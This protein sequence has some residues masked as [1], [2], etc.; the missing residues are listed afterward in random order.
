VGVAPLAFTGIFALYRTDIWVP[1]RTRP[2]L[3]A[4]RD[5]RS[6]RLVMVFGRLRSDATPGQTSADLTSSKHNSSYDE[7]DLVHD[8]RDLNRLGSR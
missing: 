1:M 8:R 6:R 7:K 3:A 4:M 2:R 5:D